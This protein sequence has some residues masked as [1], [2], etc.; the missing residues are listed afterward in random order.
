MGAVLWAAMGTTTMK[1]KIVTIVAPLACLALVSCKV[2]GFGGGDKD[3]TGQVVATVDG[4]EITL[5]EVR[6]EMSGSPAPPNAQ[7][8]KAIQENAIQQII[9]RKLM[10]QAAHEQGLDKSPDFA[11]QKQRAGQALLAQALQKQLTTSVPV[12]SKAD[13]EAFVA[14]HPGMFGQRKIM[15]VD[16]IRMPIPSNPAELKEMEPMHSL[17]EIE[18]WLNSKGITYQ[19]AASVLDT[20]GADPNMIAQLDKLPPGEPFI[21]PAGNVLLINDIRD[22]KLAPFTGEAATNYAMGIVRNQKL[23]EAVAKGVDNLVKV[24]ASKIKYNASF[25]PARPL[26]APPPAPAAKPPLPSVPAL[27]P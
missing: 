13:A 19:R 6:T 9:I 20:A 4:E 22:T 18:A 2:P 21:L 17:G 10:A 1:L 25:K 24:N 16:Q 15:T 7:A 5:T 12:P 8:A 23:Q 26:G 3:P 27:K 14:S 11:I